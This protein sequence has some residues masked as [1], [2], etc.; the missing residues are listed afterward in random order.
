MEMDGEEEGD[1][2]GGRDRQTDGAIGGREAQ[3]GSRK[4]ADTK[5]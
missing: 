4:R 2:H 5:R 3:K 1:R